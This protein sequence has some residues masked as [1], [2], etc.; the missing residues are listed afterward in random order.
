ME[1]KDVKILEEEIKDNFIAMK[2]CNDALKTMKKV[3][4]IVDK[5]ED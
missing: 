2:A 3:E 4:E 5:K 1:D